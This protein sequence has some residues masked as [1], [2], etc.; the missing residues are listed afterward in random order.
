MKIH[1]D[2]VFDKSGEIIGFVDTGDC[3]NKI[4]SLENLCKGNKYDNIATHMLT[5]MVR[6]LFIRLNFPYAQFPT[7]GMM[8][9]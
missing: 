7:S 6:G 3:N 4:R 9:A 1:A 5:L 8:A 2:L